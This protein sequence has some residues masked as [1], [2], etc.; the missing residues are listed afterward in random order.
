[1]NKAWQNTGEIS[2][3]EVSEAN[4]EKKHGEKNK[5]EGVEIGNRSVKE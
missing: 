2:Q 5:E 3:K 4:D 1:M